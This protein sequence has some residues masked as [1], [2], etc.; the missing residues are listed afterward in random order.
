MTV[1]F[2][3]SCILISFFMIAGFFTGCATPIGTQ[4]S[5][6][7]ILSPD[8][9]DNIGGS[10]LES[11]DIRTIAARMCPEI[12][13]VP[14]IANADAPVRVAIAP[15]Q[16]STCYIFDKDILSR[17]LRTELSKYANGRVR[18]FSQNAGG[19]RMRKMI[20]NERDED[21]WEETLSS[22]ADALVA[23]RL[24]SNAV[25][26]VKVKLIAPRNVNLTDMNADSFMI[27]LRSAILEKAGGKIS[28]LSSIFNDGKTDTNADVD[29]LLTGEFFAESIKNEEV[30]KSDA[31]MIGWTINQSEHININKGSLLLDKGSSGM[32]AGTTVK[33]EK[34]PNVAKRL[35]VLLIDART[36]N[37]VFS[38]LLKMDNKVKT[39]LGRADIVLTGDIK[40]LHKAAG[41]NRSDYI[42]VTFQLVDYRLNEI[43]W[44]GE[45][46]TKKVTNRSAVYK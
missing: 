34:K 33:T 14:E 26:P 35:S 31:S 3:Q 2:K 5:H 16:N 37:I 10:F 13:S 15:M 46:E 12:L 4:P 17:K 32:V 9:A 19:Q 11:S 7:R 25:K 1:K 39:G 6:T 38:K 27:I 8:E 21:M 41:G 30:Q 44:E 40:G 24:I 23:S 36:Q 45:Y 28:F 22:A 20:I 42:L 43:L 29:Y 18:F